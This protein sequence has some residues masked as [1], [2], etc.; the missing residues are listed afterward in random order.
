[1][2]RRIVS[3]LGYDKTQDKIYG[4]AANRKSYV[5]CSHTKCVSVLEESW[6][7][8]RRLQSTILATEIVFIPE[9]GQD[10]TDAPIAVYN[11]IDDVGNKWAGNFYYRSIQLRQVT[12]TTQSRKLVKKDTQFSIYPQKLC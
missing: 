3:I 9:T 4:V 5:R 1:M 2:D 11:L 8:I 6:L 12:V 7:K 10:F